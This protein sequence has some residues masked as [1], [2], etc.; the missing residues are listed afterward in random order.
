MNSQI[1]K[2]LCFVVGILSFAFLV[3]DTDWDVTPITNHE[4]HS[5][6]PS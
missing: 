1:F 6:F 4:N 3:K 5:Y 2:V